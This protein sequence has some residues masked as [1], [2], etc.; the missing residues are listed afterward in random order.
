MNNNQLFV[1]FATC[2]NNPCEN[3]IIIYT[4]DTTKYDEQK[5]YMVDFDTLKNQNEWF[6]GEKGMVVSITSN[7]DD[8]SYSNYATYEEGWNAVKE[9]AA[10]DNV[11]EIYIEG[12]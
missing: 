3:R 4:N 8:D 1:Q 5:Y 2:V 6:G 11:N 12:Y 9:L 7:D 10:K